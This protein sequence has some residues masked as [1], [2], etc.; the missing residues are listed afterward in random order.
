MNNQSALGKAEADIRLI[1]RSHGRDSGPVMEQYLQESLPQYSAAQRQAFLDK[2]IEEFSESSRGH[3]KLTGAPPR[4]DAKSLSRLV[5]L[6]FGSR[7]EDI[8]CSS[9]EFVEKLANSLNTIFDSLNELI[10]GI[11]ATLMGNAEGTEETIRLVI[12]SHIDSESGIMPL[13]QY[14]KQ[15]KEAFSISHKAFRDA[16]HSKM[17]EMLADL[18][19]ENIAKQVESGIKMGPFR[20]AEMYVIFTEKYQTMENW[21]NSGVFMEALLREFEKNCHKLFFQKRGGK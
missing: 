9:E 1:Y 20:K 2:L 14:L 18:S 16:A 21:L 13:E 5:S 6:L 11:N 12:S 8:D 4:I 10:G 15:I 17:K 3:G 19:P 7:Y